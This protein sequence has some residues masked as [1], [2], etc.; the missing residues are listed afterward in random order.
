MSDII[1]WVKRGK[2]HFTLIDPDKQLPE[3]AGELARK[4]EEFGSDAIMIGGS[5]AGHGVTDAV[6]A[7]IKQKSKLPTILFPSTAAGLT[8]HADYIF[9]MMLMNSTDRRFLVGEQMKAAP[10]IKKL[11]IKTIPMGYIVVS[12]SK[13]PTTVEKVGKVDKILPEETDKALAYA[14]T[15]QYYGM[16]CIYLEAGSGAEKPVPDEMISAV[17]KSI[18]IPLIVGGGVRDSVAAKKVISAGADILVT[19]TIAER[20]L[21]KLKEIISSVK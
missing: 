3:A 19:G 8:K 9:W 21:Q 15:A 4:S 13:N 11:G 20:D 17:K 10:Y 12:T 6:T 7:A 18:N 2:L 14:L 16:D 5:T 1:E